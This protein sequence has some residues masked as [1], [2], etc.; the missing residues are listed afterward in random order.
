MKSVREVLFSTI[1][2]RLVD[3]LPREILASISRDEYRGGKIG[4]T[5]W[6]S[7]VLY[8]RADVTDGRSVS[9]AAVEHFT[10]GT[11]SPTDAKEAAGFFAFAHLLQLA[12][13]SDA[14]T[15]SDD[16]A[17]L[18]VNQEFTRHF[19]RVSV[20]ALSE[21][22]IRVRSWIKQAS[23]GRLRL[24]GGLPVGFVADL[25]KAVPELD[26]ADRLELGNCAGVL[27]DGLAAAACTGLVRA[28]PLG[29]V[30]NGVDRVAWEKNVDDISETDS[31]VDTF[32]VLLLAALENG[33]VESVV[34]R[35]AKYVV[36][37]YERL[38]TLALPRLILYALMSPELPESEVWVAWR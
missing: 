4:A 30:H 27:L 17:F 8:D 22:P 5:A 29:F 34:V 33:L 26:N 28:E 1:A 2:R 32:Q 18:E 31:R 20:A 11:A 9:I 35:R 6:L 15:L 38:L 13:L 3:D 14:V 19:S 12:G 25:V 10:S 36:T 21:L 7:Q 23:H 24:P 37:G 16:S